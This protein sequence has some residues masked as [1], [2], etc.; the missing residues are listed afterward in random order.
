MMGDTKAE[1]DDATLTALK[2]CSLCNAS[3]ISQDKDGKWVGIGSPTEVHTL[4]VS[5]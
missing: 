1:L 5:E 4:N 2:V 3:S